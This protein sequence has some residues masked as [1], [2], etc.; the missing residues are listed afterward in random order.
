MSVRPNQRG[1][2]GRPHSLRKRSFEHCQR[3]PRQSCSTGK[4]SFSCDE[5]K[6]ARSIVFFA[7][8]ILSVLTIRLI[9]GCFIRSGPTRPWAGS[10][11]RHRSPCPLPASFKRPYTANISCTDFPFDYVDPRHYCEK[12]CDQ[13][14]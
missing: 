5:E 3:E 8:V 9:H 7:V 13:C 11:S 14:T 4:D 10:D 1:Q 12:G 6:M 2:F